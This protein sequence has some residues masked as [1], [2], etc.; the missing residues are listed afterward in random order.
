MLPDWRLLGMK[1][2]DCPFARIAIRAVT[3]PRVQAEFKVVVRID[4]PGQ[5]HIAGQVDFT[6]S[7]SL[8]V[9]D[10]HNGLVSD[11][12]VLW[13]RL[14]WPDGNVRICQPEFRDRDRTS[15]A[16]AADVA[17]DVK[18]RP[19]IA[20]ALEQVFASCSNEERAFGV[21]EAWLLANVEHEAG[22]LHRLINDRQ[23]TRGDFQFERHVTGAEGA[24]PSAG[25][26][27]R[28]KFAQDEHCA[29]VGDAGRFADERLQVGDV[30]KSE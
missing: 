15:R 4:E 30:I 7:E 26:R 16:R 14:A 20:Y 28:M 10:A 2:V 6:C 24:L 3:Q 8:S 5:M 11:F 12:D 27:L 1:N 13:T 23:R 25:V 29:V 21:T 17:A 9:P 19:S 18:S 22:I